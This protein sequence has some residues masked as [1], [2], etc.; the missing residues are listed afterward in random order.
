MRK[1]RIARLRMRTAPIAALWYQMRMR[2]DGRVAGGALSE[3]HSN[4]TGAM[5]S[6]LHVLCGRL[7][8]ALTVIMDPKSSQEGRQEAHKFCEEFKERSPLCVPCGL[9]L[10]NR[11]HSP[12]VRHFGLH[13]LEHVIKFRWN[14]MSVDDRV[15]VK[16]SVMLLISHGIHPI[17]EE[18]GHI[19]DVIARVVVEIIKR[20]WPWNW[21]GMVNELAFTA[22]FGDAQME[23]VM[24]ILLRLAEEIGPLETRPICQPKDLHELLKENMDKIFAFVV[25]I[26]QRCVP[27][28]QNLT[29]GQFRVAAAALRTLAGYI[30]CLPTHLIM[31]DNCTLLW[32]LCV[33]LNVPELQMEAAECLLLAVNKKGLL[34][35][36]R[37]P[38]LILFREDALRYI[39]TAA[40]LADSDPLQERN[41]VILKMIGQILCDL[42]NQLCAQVTAFEVKT[43]ETFDRYLEALLSLTRHP[44][45]FLTS[46]AAEVWG[47]LFNHRV[48]SHDPQLTA[49]I[50]DVLRAA[51]VSIVKV[52]YPS[53]DNSPS[54]EY[55]RMDFDDDTEFN[56]FFLSFHKQMGI[57]VRSMCR[58]DTR[59]VLHVATEWMRH[60]L[61]AP[62]DPGPHN[63][64]SVEALC[65]PHSP[66][67][68][69][70]EAMSFFCSEVFA[71]LCRPLSA[72][73]VLL[74]QSVSLLQQVISY[75]TKDPLIVSCVLTN[76][77]TL[78]PFICHGSDL[79][80][81]MLS[82]LLSAAGFADTDSVKVPRTLLMNIRSC[83]S[84]LLQ[85]I[86]IRFP[87]LVGPHFE[88]LHT[89]IKALLGQ[90][91]LLADA[92]RCALMG[93]LV[94]ASNHFKNYNRQ[95]SIL[96]ELLQPAV[97]MLLSEEMQRVLSG[98]SEFVSFLRANNPGSE[99]QEEGDDG[100]RLSYSKLC[101]CAYTFL[102]A[103]R[104]SRR[105]IIFKEAKAGG[106]V[107]GCTPDGVAMLQNPCAGEL[108]K[109]LDRLLVLIRTMNSLYLPEVMT[110]MAETSLKMAETSQSCELEM[111][112][113]SIM[114]CSQP[115]MGESVPPVT[116]PEQLQGPYNSLYKACC[117]ILGKCGPSMPHEFYSVPDL[118]S[119]LLS[120]AFTNLDYVS[121]LN[122]RH[123]V[124]DLVTPLIFY[125]P[126]KKYQ[127]VALPILG[128][129]LMSLYQ[130]LSQKWLCINQRTT[131]SEEDLLEE[132]SESQDDLMVRLLSR[133]VVQFIYICC[134]ASHTTYQSDAD[135]RIAPR[136]EQAEA[137]EEEENLILMAAAAKVLKSLALS[138]LG[139]F[140][141]SNEEVYTALLLMA[142]SSLMWK[143][144]QTCNMAA[145]RLCWSLLS[146]RPKYPE[147]HGLMEQVPNIQRDT[148]ERFDKNLL[149]PDLEI[150]E[151]MCREQFAKLLSGC[152]E[153]PLADQFYKVHIQHLP[154]GFKGTSGPVLE[155]DSVPISCSLDPTH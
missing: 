138:K 139:Q 6:Q 103:I 54:C 32:L 120:S 93:A 51:M 79:L 146:Q 14:V 64:T 36:E 58:L 20:E 55:S 149:S 42:G 128:P 147:L 137:D 85:T 125:C 56:T 78:L 86:C 76:L 34:L 12:C 33:L 91:Q 99:N 52:G 127:S 49:A 113:K 88:V 17:L 97:S 46:L 95:R 134:M 81:L 150:N 59:T 11:S 130:R 152:T 73:E 75:E 143:D 69:H 8:R 90:E 141:L 60:Q 19:K 26:L 136:V 41:Y 129:L 40:Q 15:F 119:R 151:R 63:A 45:L 115:I 123:I 117:Q 38:L 61:S 140:L 131:A 18:K 29:Q 31:A 102:A 67:F 121:D 70:W 142:Y 39:L 109:V 116:V 110:K 98:P 89:R 1:H 82:K 7:V 74:T 21:L 133:T 108:L 4:S 43:P 145:T 112:N 50:P 72:E 118:A 47:T 9:Q 132:E 37:V 135:Y 10:S 2:N 126:S 154:A 106:F 44:S 71:Q 25:T 107:K 96:E 48:L 111:G 27:N 16:N 105:P 57:V 30:K 66:S 155:P 62:L 35:E 94:L 153:K 148:L 28:C 68:L 3:W 80:P 92:E 53:M 77:S 24:F 122:L 13:V 65:S 144:P 84:A 5:A 87:D 100:G 83:A 23:L 101:Y 104:K 114:D 124:I 22:N